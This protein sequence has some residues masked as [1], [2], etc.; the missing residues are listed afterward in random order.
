MLYNQQFPNSYERRRNDIR[1]TYGR[2]VAHVWKYDWKACWYWCMSMGLFFRG[3]AHM[4]IFLYASVMDS[5]HTN[6]RQ[7]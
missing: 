4:K 3:P 6:L 5:I 1:L 2:F 7:G